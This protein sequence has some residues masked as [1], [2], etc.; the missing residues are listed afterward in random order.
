MHTT[1]TTRVYIVLLAITTTRGICI[2][3]TGC[4]S[5][6]VIMRASHV[7]KIDFQDWSPPC[8]LTFALM[9]QVCQVDV[10]HFHYFSTF[11]RPLQEGALIPVLS[12]HI[13]P[14]ATDLVC[15]TSVW[16][17]NVDHEFQ[18]GDSSVGATFSPI[19]P[20]ERGSSHRFQ[21]ET[22]VTPQRT[23]WYHLNQTVPGYSG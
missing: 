18:S 3:H 1:T 4:C 12:P 6:W 22:K 8:D 5:S 21:M 16:P 7:S 9:C 11:R 20:E 23:L 10:C 19:V 15:H 14:I 17:C 2:R 13:F